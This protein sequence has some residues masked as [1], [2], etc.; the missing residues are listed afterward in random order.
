MRVP[1]QI[2]KLGRRNARRCQLPF[3]AMPSLRAAQLSAATPF[4]GVAAFPAE[5][6][7]ELENYRPRVLVGTAAE[8][9]AL[10]ER[11][12]LGLIDVGSVD[13]ALFVH[14]ECGEKPASDVLKVV[15]WQAFGVP[16]YEVFV[17]SG[18]LLA[19]EC[20]A[21]EGWHVESN[22][23]FS[24]VRNELFVNA[25]IKASTGLSGTVDGSTCPCG[26]AGTRLMDLSDLSTKL[27]NELAATA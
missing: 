18:V 10:A 21:H 27:S 7:Q 16:V 24:V 1:I 19:F 22:A 14:T 4:D 26:Q 12:E 25:P 9:R 8:L 17:A 23:E 2:G 15:L 6:W 20:E 3:P 13:H 5:R 11:S